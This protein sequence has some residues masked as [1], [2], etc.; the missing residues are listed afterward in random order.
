MDTE[1]LNR[2][3][4]VA[5]QI[6]KRQETDRSLELASIRQRRMLPE[7]PELEKYEFGLRYLPAAKVSG[8][9]Y[10]FIPV[11]DGALG[12][13]VADVTGHGVEAGIIMGMA[14]QAIAI[15]GRQVESPAEVLCRTNEE[16]HRSLD[17]RTF[18]SLSYAV[19]EEETGIIRFARA[20]QCKPI[21]INPRWKTAEP[22]VVESRGLTLGVDKGPRF[23]KL[24]EE[25]ELKLE[26]GDVFF[27]YTDGLVEATNK[28]K[29]QFGEEQLMELLK[30]YGRASAQEQVDILLESLKEF[31]RV[32][33]LEDDVTMVVL[34]ARDTKT[35]TRAVRFDLGDASP[36]SRKTPPPIGPEPPPAP[37][38]PEGPETELPDWLK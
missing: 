22:Q 3:R 27:Q 10:D 19:L 26:A 20:G 11:K 24:I 21:L 5:S 6:Q 25:I 30:R 23:R 35:L 16:L 9:F 34:K 13:V 2:L 18:V 15:F 14:K 1:R 37:D 31:T 17:A 38:T 28:D 32:P 4:K 29:E 12:I 7:K 33:E 8:D 36:V